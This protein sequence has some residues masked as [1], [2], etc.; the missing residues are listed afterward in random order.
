MTG[1]KIVSVIVPVYN[2]SK[3]INGLI[4]SLLKQDFPRE[5]SE[6]LFIDGNSS[7]GTKEILGT[8][9]KEYPEP[10]YGVRSLESGVNTT[11]QQQK[12]D[13]ARACVGIIL[14][15]EHVGVRNQKIQRGIQKVHAEK[16]RRGNPHGL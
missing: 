2:E 15:A 6:W 7:D 14:F 3:Y 16:H 4:G 9:E 5:N 10:R 11:S 12:S 1:G 8:Y 13:H